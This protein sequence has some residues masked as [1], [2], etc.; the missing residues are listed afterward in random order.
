MGNFKL[1]PFGVVVLLVLGAAALA[2][3]VG[4]G[5]LRGAAVLVIGVVVLL[6]ASEGVEGRGGGFTGSKRA[7]LRRNAETD[8]VARSRK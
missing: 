4:S 7:V 5:A 2:A 6:W 3:V 1:T 8:R